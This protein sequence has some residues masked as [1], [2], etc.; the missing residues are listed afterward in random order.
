[1]R[2]RTDHESGSTQKMHD[3]ELDPFFDEYRVF[4][5][6]SSWGEGCLRRR[7]E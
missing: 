2:I 4:A 7:H 3:S 5:T 6:G 1:L